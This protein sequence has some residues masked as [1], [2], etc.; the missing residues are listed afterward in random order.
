M[1]QNNKGS[2]VPAST[3]IW[4]T[5]LIEQLEVWRVSLDFANL[6]QTQER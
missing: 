6:F 3:K 1:L 4:Q 5:K 2:N